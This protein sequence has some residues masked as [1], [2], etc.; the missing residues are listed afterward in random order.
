M[1]KMNQSMAITRI[2]EKVIEEKVEF[3]WPDFVS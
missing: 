1:T 3:F 2:T